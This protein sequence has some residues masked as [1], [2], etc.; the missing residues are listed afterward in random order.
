MYAGVRCVHMGARVV[1]AAEQELEIGDL[2]SFDVGWYVITMT[3][4]EDSHGSRRVRC[5]GR[6][7]LSD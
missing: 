4:R 7:L 3:Q 1:Y 2:D 5:G 6:D